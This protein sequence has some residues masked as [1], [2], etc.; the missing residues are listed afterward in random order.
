MCTF[1]PFNVHTMYSRWQVSLETALFCVCLW[2]FWAPAYSLPSFGVRAEKWRRPR[3]KRRQPQCR[4]KVE[5][6]TRRNIK[7]GRAE[8]D[9][10]WLTERDARSLEQI[11]PPVTQKSLLSAHSRTANL[12]S[13]ICRRAYFL[14]HLPAAEKIPRILHLTPESSDVSFNYVKLFRLWMLSSP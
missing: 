5:M 3:V 1:Y 9:S 7:S 13:L 8:E 12:D 10:H 11:I 14:L 4:L 2:D 6:P